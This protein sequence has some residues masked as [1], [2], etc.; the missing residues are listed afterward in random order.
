MR[1]IGHISN[2]TGARSFGDYLTAEGIPNDVEPGD[3]GQW[4]VWVHE[5]DH[6]ERAQTLLGEFQSNS[7]DPKY[8]QAAAKAHKLRE[9]EKREE[10]AQAK[11]MFD[12]HS[13]WRGASW[14]VGW[15]TASLVAISIAVAGVRLLWPENHPLI[16]AL[17]IEDYV[18]DGHTID[19]LSGLQEIRSGQVWRLITP[20]FI[21]FGIAHILGNALWLLDLASMIEARRGTRTL[22]A[23]VIVTAVVSNLAQYL[24]SQSPTFG[25]MSGVVYALFG[26]IWMRSKFDPRSGLF[27][28]SNTIMF[29]IVWFFLCMTGW[30]GPIA[31]TAHAAGLG[32]GLAWGFV[33]AKL[34]R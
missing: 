9:Q 4:N 27:L 8:R 10:A 21:H 24:A 22:A 11:R 1:S 26:F 31:N 13:L 12:R 6:L 16:R 30:V 7:A 3:H 28:D 25:G 23:L 5:D 14:R 15:L 2:E 33:S 18:S 34:S 29:A 19:R 17:S 20:I 32:V